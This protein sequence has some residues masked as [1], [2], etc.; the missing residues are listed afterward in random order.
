MNIFGKICE[1]FVVNRKMSML[2]FIGIV[3]WGVISFVVTPKQYNPEITA[4]A[5]EVSVDF[6]GA[7]S[8][9][10]YELVTKPLED[11]IYE[12]PGVD[13]LYSQSHHGGKGIVVVQFFVGEDFDQSKIRLRQRIDSNLDLKPLGVTSV[14]IKSIDP[15]N[16]AVMTVGLV[17]D[18]L[19]PVGLRKRAFEI[20]NE[21]KKVKGTS[22][23]KVIGGKKREFQIKLDPD[24]MRESKTS[25]QEVELALSKSSLLSVLGK[26][27]SPDKFR[28]IETTG[29]VRN[30][31]EINNLVIASNVERS[32]KIKDIAEVVEGVVEE[33]SFVNY[34][35]KDKGYEN[36]VMISIAKKKGQNISSI[37]KA[38]H[39]KIDQ[40][41]KTTS[42]FK[43]LEVLIL[44]DEGRVA[45][46]EISGLTF[47]LLQAICIVFIVLL[48]FL[49]V[50]AAIMVA[51]TIPLTL[52]TVFGIGFLAGQTINR[53]T[54]FA[55]ILSLGLLVDSA[56]VVVENIVR[57]KKEHADWSNLK[58]ITE[59]VSEV[60]VGLFL[61]TLT[62]VLA[63]IPMKFV[64]GMMGPYMGPL[65]FFVSVAICVSLVYSYTIVPWMAS[66]FCKD[67]ADDKKQKEGCFKRIYDRFICWYAELI[68]GILSSAKR[69]RR[70]LITCLVLVLVV[71]LIPI[72]ELLRFRMLPKANREQMYVYI[73]LD[74]GTS[75]DETYKITKELSQH[76]KKEP[77]IKGIQS[78]VGT[79][80][81]LDFNGLF[82]GAYQRGATHMA[83]LKL[84]LT[85]PDDRPLKSEDLALIY[86]DKV[87]AFFNN[88]PKVKFQII[89]DPPGPPVRSTFFVK[90][91]GNDEALVKRVVN[92]L[93]Q[94]SRDIKGVEDVDTSMPEP[95]TKYTLRVDTEKA[96]VSKVS[97]AAIARF[98]EVLYHG[99]VI[100]VYH[101]DTN[102]EQE[103]I[104]LKFSK[105]YR[106]SI[107]DF[108]QFTITNEL[109]N[110]VLVN[111]FLKIEKLPNSDVINSDNRE[112]VVYISAEMGAR[113]I[114]YAA[115]DFLKALA[116]YK[117]P[118]LELTKGKLNLWSAEYQTPHHKW[119]KVEIDGEWLM[120]LEVFRDLGLAMMIA[121][122]LIYLV[123]VAQFRT[124]VLPLLILGTVPLALVGVFPGFA[125]LFWVDDIYFSATSMIGVIALSGIVVNNAIIL[126]EY[127]I[128]TKKAGAD[129]KTA[130]VEAC[131]IRLRPIVLT[132]LTTILG[133]LA[134]AGDPVWAGLAWSVVFGL[135]L[136]AALTLLV[137][138][139]LI[140]Q[141]CDEKVF[142]EL[143]V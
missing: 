41:K 43:D 91:K 86:R 54:L 137:F 129:F 96:A 11:V 42:F 22:I 8:H 92:D 138:P 101:D 120:T 118:E 142:N 84:N 85:H 70:F 73:D 102:L 12:I 10:V 29:T 87:K 19:G 50:R 36:M 90:V 115:I 38:L 27:K 56:T 83:T 98:L 14:N 127:I 106:D 66:L 116:E 2:L 25:I 94:I 128:H 26:V 63:F 3:L 69:R 119:V 107:K 23:V 135:S 40:L 61:S 89:E 7:T 6:D 64:T 111:K 121:I 32:L 51:I 9:E 71:L 143:A 117:V 113:S 110:P 1:Y 39:Q 52:L 80:P 28:F 109:G 62:T 103:Y 122:I 49:N 132:S 134:I 17:S 100:G 35:S 20:K 133:S 34:R 76:L 58:V 33:D 104:T 53:I 93:D 72:F 5:F 123:L 60:G 21:L 81:I 141:F 59:S 82:K 31:D 37:T 30:I 95:L 75:I 136:S 15:D 16:L 79:A 114:T 77:N 139:A 57:N 68:N 97:T 18:E 130:I 67:H 78:F 24:K 44:K 13:E 105:K 125:F 131:S 99:S 126:L 65:P 4:P 47:N 88:D 45:K 48:F 108:D 46:E 112:K 140:Y 124:Y 74:Q 55:L